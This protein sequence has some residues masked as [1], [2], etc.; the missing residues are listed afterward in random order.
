MDMDI[1]MEHIF[2]YGM[3]RDSGRGLLDNAIFC[4]FTTVDGKI[5][6]VNESYPGFV[7]SNSGKVVGNVYLIDPSIFPDLDEFEGHEYIRT[8]I[9]TNNDIECW[10]YEYKD[11]V[12]KFSEIKCGDW[13]LR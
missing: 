6:R 8:K 5:Y 9:R 4:G 2:V 10:I 7:K 1:N 13:F 11:D 12:S 3:F